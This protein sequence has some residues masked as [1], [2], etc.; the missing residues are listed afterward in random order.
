MN[1]LRNPSELLIS[2]EFFGFKNTKMILKIWFSQD[3]Q[4]RHCLFKFHSN[5]NFNSQYIEWEWRKSPEQGS[6]LQGAQS[7]SHDQNHCAES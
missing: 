7:S 3:D 4:S 5:F 1:S 2:N 6:N